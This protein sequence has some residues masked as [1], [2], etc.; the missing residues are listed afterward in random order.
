MITITLRATFLVAQRYSETLRSF[1][2]MTLP[3]A[4]V[5]HMADLAR[6]ND[7]E[8]QLSGEQ[9][10]E[11][12][13]VAGKLVPRLCAPL[14]RLADGCQY[15]V[16][17]DGSLLFR[18]PGGNEVWADAGD[19]CRDRLWATTPDGDF[20]PLERALVNYVAGL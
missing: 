18:S 17:K 12:A 5:Q 13:R 16:F 2:W 1:S 10:E 9:R 14:R 7:L 19:F 6:G 15:I 3:Q 4:G 20:E 11:L 8:G